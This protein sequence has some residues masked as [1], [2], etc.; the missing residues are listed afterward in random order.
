M[1]A[2]PRDAGSG[3][4]SF[5]VLDLRNG[6]VARIDQLRRDALRGRLRRLTQNLFQEIGRPQNQPAAVNEIFVRPL[7]DVN[8][9]A[10]SAIFVETSTGYVVY[11]EQLGR[12]STFGRITTVIGRPFADIAAPDGRFALLM[13][14]GN[15]GRTEGAY[16][17]HAS[18]G[19]ALYFG[20]LAKLEIDPTMV[21]LSGL[22]TLAGQVTAAELQ[23]DDEETI[24]FLV[25]DSSDGSMRYFDLDPD[26]A[27]RVTVRES[28]LSLF[29]T[30]NEASKNPSPQRFVA[31]P[32]Q[33]AND[34]T[35]HVFFIDVGNGETALLE[36]V[37]NT[38]RPVMRKLPL[39][40][41]SVLRTDASEVPRTV[42]AVPR[43]A[44]NGATTGIWLIDSVTRA[45]AF[46]DDP[47]TP[48]DTTLRRVV[49]E[50]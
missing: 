40:L 20:G 2:I 44:S 19:R 27:S 30:F 31:V 42:S 9:N 12:G 10:R 35:E 8:R 3:L 16:L 15:N 11:F 13:R 21:T 25:A 41:Y 6:A 37:N 45:I 34:N 1:V 22:P 7:H 18:T 14:Q 38:S 24:A 50:N 26:A 28:P 4:D 32:V 47:G 43:I 39:N 29:P 17:Y 33:G 48:G 5:F 36:N 23:S 46:V 49:P